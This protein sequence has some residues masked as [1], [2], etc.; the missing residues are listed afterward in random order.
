MS[1]QSIIKFYHEGH[2]YLTVQSNHS[3]YAYDMVLSSIYSLLALLDFS[4]HKFDDDVIDHLIRRVEE[5][6][7][8]PH[9]V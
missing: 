2:N 5:L 9:V 1:F 8:C 6:R 3:E 7:N 4:D